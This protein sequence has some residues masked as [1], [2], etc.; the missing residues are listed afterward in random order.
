MLSALSGWWFPAVCVTPFDESNDFLPCVHEFSHSSRIYRRFSYENSFLVKRK[1][2]RD[3]LSANRHRA[4]CARTLT[5]T[6]IQH[7][8]THPFLHINTTTSRRSAI[9]LNVDRLPVRSCTVPSHFSPT[10][11]ACTAV[12]ARPR[13]VLPTAVH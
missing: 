6:H 8:E 13:Q 5:Y 4:Y 10:G 7:T 2:C 1:I 11:Q 12:L 3:A 9:R